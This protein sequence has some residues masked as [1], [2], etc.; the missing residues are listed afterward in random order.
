MFLPQDRVQDFTKMNPQELLHNTQISV[1]SPEVVETFNKLLQVREQQKSFSSSNL[2]LKKTLDD[3]RNRNDQLRVIINSNNLRNKLIVKAELITKKKL[4]IDFNK[5]NEETK[6]IA[7]DLKS[8]TDK[9]T[10]R[11]NELNP[12]K[13]KQLKLAKAKTDIK[14]VISKATTNMIA[15]ISELDKL[16]DA[17]EKVESDVNKAKQDMRNLVM[18]VQ[19]QK[20]H[21]DELEL[22]IRLEKVEI[23]E[24]IKDSTSSNDLMQKLDENLNILKL[25]TSQL[26]QKRQK[27]SN[28]LENNIVPAIRLCERKIALLGDTQRQ[29]I[30]SLRAL[31]GDAYR[32]YEWLKANRQNFRG[33]I[34]N[35]IVTEITVNSKENAKYIENAVATKDLVAF[36]CTDKDDMAKLI[37]KFRNEMKL[38]V[39]L[40]FS[41]DTE[42]LQF[43]PPRDISEYDEHLGLHSFMIEML[44]GPAP[45]I[46]YLCRLYSIHT[47]VIGDD[48]T[49]QHAS[50]VPNECKVFF[51]TNHRFQV[52]M[53]RYSKAKSTSSSQIYPRNML[54]EGVDVTSKERE[55][56]NLAKWQQ[57]SEKLRAER[58]AVEQEMNQNEEK[59]TAVRNRKKEIQGKFQKILMSQEKLTKKEKELETLKNRKIDLDEERKRFKQNVDALIAKL[60]K[61]NDGRV[62]CL[63]E[64]KKNKI[65]H[66]LGK[67]K[68]HVFD[69]ST[70]N[71]EEE[72]RKVE[73]EIGVTTQLA[74][75]VRLTFNEVKARSKKAETEALNLTDGLAPDHPK[76]K[77]KKD[78]EKLS[79]DIEVLLNKIAELQGRIECSRGIDPRIAT[80]YE[81]RTKAIEDLEKQLENEGT[82]LARL[83]EQL[84]SFHEKWLPEVERFID[85]IN[86]KFSNFF[87]MMGFVGQ[88]ELIHKEKVRG[89][90]LNSLFILQILFYFLQQHD[91][92]DY[93]IQIRV[94]YRDSEKLQVLNR[95]V[96]S[97]GE[98]AVAIAVYTL[99]LQHITNVPF[100]C[101]DEINQG[102]DPNN[103][104]KI[105]QMLVD[106][107][108]QLGQ[109][110]YFF[111]TPKLLPDLPCND[112]M[113][114]T[115]VHNGENVED[116]YVFFADN[117]E[118]FEDSD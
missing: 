52:T 26:S 58:V 31:N 79:D 25:T 115:V 87:Q 106:I 86:R 7:V 36:I 117:E 3:N 6:V 84:N 92:A 35:P 33:K 68:L 63:I 95:H 64:Y 18:S 55:E 27:I 65:Q 11:T 42:F 60:V 61:V 103:E 41:E 72:I 66:I 46:N 107:T 8:L 20:K 56:R 50:Q 59:A 30:D 94:Q 67:K 13:E 78:F 10:K 98:R 116:P 4:W 74:E 83:G 21:S 108:C 71:V 14:N 114:V 38:Q 23:E 57:D 76:F 51:S 2:D 90:Q 85:I 112:L 69:S 47:I 80:E 53:S 34:F 96:Q 39:N 77:Y 70:G 101:V 22:M 40:A 24:A 19:D 54:S 102:M 49:F 110:Q 48:R 16:Q 15:T 105:F 43:E 75:R 82:R 9:I 93:G 44:E 28:T 29:R 89:F 113:T 100:R 5:L 104:R 97:G 81:T 12:F 73:N 118:E 17:S 37:R 109:S 62:N 32:A 91:Y 45:V 99:S 111:V 1:C 88:V